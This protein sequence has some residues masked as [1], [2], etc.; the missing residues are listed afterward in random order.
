MPKIN[1]FI[2]IIQNSGRVYMIGDKL[3]E[4]PKK[5][6]EKIIEWNQGAK[7]YESEYDKKVCHMLL[8]SLVSKESLRKREV[9]E[10]VIQFIKGDFLPSLLHTYFRIRC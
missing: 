3:I 1:H 7:R 10:S 8:L 4:I 2:F 9:N 6:V 5:V